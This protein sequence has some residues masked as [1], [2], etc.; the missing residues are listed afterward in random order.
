MRRV[1]G[2]W[3]DDASNMT[4]SFTY[5]DGGNSEPGES[6]DCVVLN[7]DKWTV[8]DCDAGANVVCEVDAYTE[9]CKFI[10]RQK[11]TSSVPKA[12]KI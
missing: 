6:G 1:G 2:D 11:Y 5:W 10:S 4:V 8:V 3:V 7:N 9:G 12:Y